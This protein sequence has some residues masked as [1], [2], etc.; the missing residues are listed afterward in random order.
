[1][2]NEKTKSAQ[3]S[4]QKVPLGRLLATPGAIEKIGSEEI[5]EALSRHLKGDW[6]D[7]D[8]EDAQSND[9]ALV[10]GDR[11]LSAYRTQGG[12]KFWIITEWDRS[13]TT[14]LLPDEY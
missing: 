1:M 4:D 10:Q 13:V 2:K 8:K 9:S 7:V 3:Q 5:H 11:L 6:G 14:V 12:V